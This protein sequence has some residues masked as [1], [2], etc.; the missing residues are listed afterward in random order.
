MDKFISTN[1]KFQV[2][3][4]V[5][6][7]SNNIILTIAKEKKTSNMERPSRK[8][9]LVNY[10]DFL[11]LDDDEDFASA[12]APPSKKAKESVKEPSQEKSKKPSSKSSVQETGSQH[13]GCIDRLE[14]VPEAKDKSRKPLESRLYER[15]LDAALTLS[16]LQTAQIIVEQRPTEPENNVQNQP[17][18]D[19]EYLDPSLQLSNC[20]VD[21][22]L[23]GLDQITNDQGSPCSPSRQRKTTSKTTKHPSSMQKDDNEDYLPKETSESESDGDLSDPDESDDEFTLKKSEGGEMSKREK[24][25]RKEKPKGKPQ[26]ASKKEKQPSKRLKSEQHLTGT[27]NLKTPTLGRSPT[28]AKS[29]TAPKRPPATPPVSKP[30]VSG[31]PAGGRIPKWNPP[32]Q[33][34]RSPGSSQNAQ[35]KSPGQGLR[36]GLS[37]MVRVKP[38]HP[39]VAIN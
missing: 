2:Y 12:K 37:R 32:G 17:Q 39:G 29:V 19:G 23:F 10:S 1:L 16:L 3:R 26:A 30:A 14:V 27:P 13:N 24:D 21:I 4:S 7:L 38:L 31:S 22:N 33:V 6:H 18:K 36:L 20:S 34:G 25:A 15:D 35:M 28:A 9:K 11:D 5:K 8:T